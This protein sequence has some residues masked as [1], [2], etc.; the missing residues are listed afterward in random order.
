MDKDKR[1]HTRILLIS[2]INDYIDTLRKWLEEEDYE[3]IGIFSVTRIIEFVQEL[4]PNIILLN[5]E[6]DEASGIEI[7]HRLKNNSDTNHIPI[8]FIHSE[9][10]IFL[11]KVEAGL[12]TSFGR[13]DAL[14]LVNKMLI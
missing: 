9:E 1:T 12:N 11:Y 5:V 13:T 8:L 4:Q 10:N 6:I 3:V 7:A 14:E 2:E